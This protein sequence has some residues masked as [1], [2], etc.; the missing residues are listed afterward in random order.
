MRFL[1]LVVAAVFLAPAAAIEQ[2]CAYCRYCNFCGECEKCPCVKS[3][4][5]PNCHLCKY[6][7]FCT[8]CRL[9]DICKSEMLAA[10][11]QKLVG[12]GAAAAGWLSGAA[13]AAGLGGMLGGSGGGDGASGGDKA[14]TS[15]AGEVRDAVSGLDEDE[16]AR[17]LRSFEQ[18]ASNHDEL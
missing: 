8:L 5:T 17:D 13:Q 11:G 2:P 3:P 1:V 12:A 16:L 4:E 9:C 14:A 7:K 6:C 10:V 15:A 18:E